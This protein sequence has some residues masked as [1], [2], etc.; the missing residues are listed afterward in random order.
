MNTHLKV[1]EQQH[2]PLNLT[3]N[4]ERLLNRIHTLAQVGALE[5]GGVC[6]LALT[7][8][9][10]QGRDLVIQWMKELGLEI[11]IDQIGNVVGL[12]QGLEDLPPVMTGSH[13]DTV[14][15]GGKYDG[16]LGV[17]AGLEVIATLNDHNIQTKHPIAVT[18]FTNEEG[19]RFPPDTMGSLVFQ[20][21]MSLETAYNIV[22]IDG[23][24]V[25]ENLQRIGYIGTAPVGSQNIH[26]F[27]ELHIEQGPV[28]EHE[29]IMIGAV[30]GV[31]GIHWIEFTIQGTSNHAG[32][33]PMALRHDAGIVAMQIATYARDLIKK[34]GQ[35]QLA[36]IGQMKLMPNLVNV[37]P[38]T[39]VFTLDIRN[40]NQ[41][42]LDETYQKILKFAQQVAQ[43]EGV[44]LLHRDIAKSAP[45][46][47]DSRIVD[48]IATIAQQQGGSVKRM[49]SGAGHDAQVIADIC[50]TGMI[51]VPSVKGLS[52]N[53]KEFTHDHDVER[54]ANILLH[55]LYQLANGHVISTVNTEVHK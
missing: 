16:N 26:A 48:C 29:Q 47:F 12:R 34:T 22:G 5:G 11:R 13:I 54:G 53:I 55:A 9:D 15:T 17:L 2:L 23:T 33:T 31:Q 8:E 51:F 40:T 10:K 28:L 4:K 18:F 42:I 38:H 49:P 20:G 44:K 37:I 25:K 1:T 7:D 36:T 46:A 3:I 43:D 35:G 19:A 27:I 6:R 41:T 24:T 30:T 39:A 45:I 50:P 21:D 52:H 14:A 32:T